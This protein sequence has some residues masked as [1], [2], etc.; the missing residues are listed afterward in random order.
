MVNPVNYSTFTLLKTQGEGTEDGPLDISD[1]VEVKNT[2]TD[3]TKNLTITRLNLYE[4]LVIFRSGLSFV[5]GWH[6]HYSEARNVK[7]P[8]EYTAVNQ[9]RGMIGSTPFQNCELQIHYCSVHIC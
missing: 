8:Q 7:V 1:K 9:S 6:H 5:L 4:I 2:Y 3:S